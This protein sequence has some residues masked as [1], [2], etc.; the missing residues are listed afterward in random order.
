V[1]SAILVLSLALL[2]AAGILHIRRTNRAVST[3]ERLLGDPDRSRRLAALDTVERE[4][5]ALHAPALYRVTQTDTDGELLDAIATLVRRSLWEPDQ[6][7]ELLRL[8]RWATERPERPQ[9]VPAPVDEPRSDLV[10]RLE[11]ALGE[12][13][14]GARLRSGEVVIDALERPT[15]AARR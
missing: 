11:T 9:R 4:G 6:T 13:L 12:R 7:A 2:T 15:R 8:R 1:L 10:T 5:V 14:V 3:V